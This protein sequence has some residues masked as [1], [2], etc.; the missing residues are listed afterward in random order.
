MEPFKDRSRILDPNDINQAI[1]KTLTKEK[2]PLKFTWEGLKNFSLL[3]E[4][5]P[6]DKLKT[7]RLK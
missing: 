5:N 6:F 2:K 3:F 7:E 4:T 1:K